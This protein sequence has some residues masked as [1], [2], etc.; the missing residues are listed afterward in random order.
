MGKVKVVRNL[1]GGG[2]EWKEATCVGGNKQGNGGCGGR[3]IDMEVSSGC[4]SI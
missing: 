2:M 1:A 4:G 3:E